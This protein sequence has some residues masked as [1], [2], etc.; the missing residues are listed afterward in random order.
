MPKMYFRCAVLGG[1]GGFASFPPNPPFTSAA[2]QLMLLL[3]LLGVE[4]AE[5]PSS[6]AGPKARAATL[7]STLGWNYYSTTSCT[8]TT[9]IL[10]D[11]NYGNNRSTHTNLSLIHA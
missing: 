7:R 5:P 1:A 3:K 4:G 9:T 10:F 2:C 8:N 11:L 6:S